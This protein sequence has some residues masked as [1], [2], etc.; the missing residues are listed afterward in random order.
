ML[1]V[2]DSQLVKENDRRKD[3]LDSMIEEEQKI[4]EVSH[5]PTTIEFRF[6]NWRYLL[7]ANK[8]RNLEEVDE[9]FDRDVSI[10]MKINIGLISFGSFCCAGRDL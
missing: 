9:V 1:E 6:A 8:K 10:H 3:A 4:A 7:Q 2:D 5:K